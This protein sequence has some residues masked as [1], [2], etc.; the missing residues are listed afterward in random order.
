MV[1]WVWLG[2]ACRSTASAGRLGRYMSMPSG[3]MAVSEPSSSTRPQGVR[4]GC[5]VMVIGPS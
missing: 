5:G 2:E 3:P 1:V 4:S